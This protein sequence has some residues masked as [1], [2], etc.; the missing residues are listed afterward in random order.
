MGHYYPRNQG[1]FLPLPPQNTIIKV[2]S[3]SDPSVVYILDLHLMTCTCLDWEK[4]RSSQKMGAY[5]RACKHL[6]R[7]LADSNT[8]INTFWR[9]LLLDK[10]KPQNIWIDESIPLLITY[11]KGKDWINCFAQND[12]N[13]FEKFG[14]SIEE[15]RWSYEKEPARYE[16]IEEIIQNNFSNKID[17]N[18]DCNKNENK[19]TLPSLNDDQKFVLKELYELCN[20]IVEDDVID[21]D[22]IML[23]SK[24]CRDHSELLYLGPF[25]AISQ[26]LGSVLEDG[27]ISSAERKILIPFIKSIGKTI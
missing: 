19:F 17:P 8:I 26:I 22:E 23:L 12:T 15:K 13:E 4:T 2:N 21:D 25:Y 3:D 10:Y 16:K 1:V 6:K 11:T 20:S 18:E 5:D 7:A 9:P 24:Y 14:Y 27:K